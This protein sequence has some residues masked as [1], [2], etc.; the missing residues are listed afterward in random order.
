MVLEAHMQQQ[1]DMQYSGDPLKVAPVSVLAEAEL[2]LVREA[3]HNLV[4]DT[5]GQTSTLARLIGK[6]PNSLSNEVSLNPTSQAKLGL[7][8]SIRLQQITQDFRILHAY[9]SALN[10]SVIPLGGFVGVSDI[11]LLNSYANWHREIGD[12]AIAVSKAL[13]DKRITRSELK[14]IRREGMEQ[15]QAFMVFLAR[16][17]ALCDDEPE[18]EACTDEL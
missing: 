8:D 15:V 14:R 18:V 12:V 13:E 4:H 7:E 6:K 11:E 5:L 1:H 9:A 16:A 3:A 17:E 2:Q 10:H